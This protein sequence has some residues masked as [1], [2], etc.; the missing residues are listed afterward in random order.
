MVP[1]PGSGLCLLQQAQ[2]TMASPMCG[3]V[4]SAGST[5]TADW[6][7]ICLHVS[8]RDAEGCSAATQRHFL[9]SKPHWS[10]VFVGPQFM[11]MKH[12]NTHIDAA[13]G[14]L[15]SDDMKYADC[16]HIR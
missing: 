1:N 11:N 16:H 3:D 6:Q 8:L 7:N 13:R 12:P 15:G 4:N 2:R 14:L 9:H 5:D 10:L